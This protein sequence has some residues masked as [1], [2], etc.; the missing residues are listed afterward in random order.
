MRAAGSSPGV[1]CLPMGRAHCGRALAGQW[2]PTILRATSR[3]IPGTRVARTTHRRSRR[4]ALF[5]GRNDEAARRPAACASST[6]GFHRSSN[7][8]SAGLMPSAEATGPR[9]SPNSAAPAIAN[10]APWPARSDTAP[11]ASPRRMVRSFCQPG[12]MIWATTSSYTCS[13]QAS[14]TLSTAALSPANS[15]RSRS[16]RLADPRP[17]AVAVGSR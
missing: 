6:T 14:S 1:G 15:R 9:K 12:K 16:R 8:A 3:S 11:E 4:W 10:E 17:P 13:G 5:R 2:L 7:P